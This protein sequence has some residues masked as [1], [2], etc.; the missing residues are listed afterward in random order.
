[1]A[2]IIR[3]RLHSSWQAVREHSELYRR[4]ARR[5]THELSAHSIF[6]P[7]AGRY[8]L[9]VSLADP[10]SHRVLMVRLL[11]NLQ[12]LV[13]FS[14]VDPVLTEQDWVFSDRPGC[15]PDSINHCQYVHQLYSTHDQNYTGPVSLPILWDRQTS[16]IVN[17]ESEAI[18]RIL[19]SAFEGNGASGIDLFPASLGKA[20]VELNLLIQEKINRG[21][22]KVGFAGT[23][24]LYD[25]TSSELFAMLDELDDRLCSQPFLL[26]SKMTEADIRLFVTLIRFD[27][28][29]VPLFR[30]HKKR[31]Q[32]YANLWPYTREIYQMS[33]VKDTVNFGFIRQYYASLKQINP[34]GI[35]TNTPDISFDEPVTTLTYEIYSQSF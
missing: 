28:C 30:C 9:Y 6:K 1:M 26:G 24:K 33:G 11:K 13:S 8:H 29:Y 5:I 27:T 7:E 34:L 2:I 10:W 19:N 18:M 20:I 22:Y 3:G 17:N 23:Q 32:D 14:I 35:L 31:L 4:E 25:K 15:T 16:Q 12:K 21:V